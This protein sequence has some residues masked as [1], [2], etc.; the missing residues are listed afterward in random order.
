MAGA[1][2]LEGV[3]KEAKKDREALSEEV[4]ARGQQLRNSMQ[5]RGHLLCTLAQAQE[6]Q[7]CGC[8]DLRWTRLLRDQ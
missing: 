5:I 2:H 6:D 3:E 8:F 4:E 1:L 7:V